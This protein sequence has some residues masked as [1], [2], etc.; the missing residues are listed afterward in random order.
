MDASA[1]SRKY[2]LLRSFHLLLQS[3][4][5][6]YLPPVKRA[7]DPSAWNTRLSSHSRSPC[8]RITGQKHPRLKPTNQ[9]LLELL[10]LWAT[11]RKAANICRPPWNSGNS[12]I[13]SSAYLTTECRP[14]AV[15][16]AR[17]Y[18]S[19]IALG[20]SPCTA[21]KIDNIFLR[22]APLGHHRKYERNIVGRHFQSDYLVQDSSD[23]C[24]SRSQDIQALPHPTRI[25]G[26]PYHNSFDGHLSHT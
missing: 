23:N 9:K 24:H 5:P 6:H 22:L 21:N 26:Y 11:A 16:I 15:N 25:R 20:T 12:H 8:K 14:I 3:S 2:S 10:V 18:E 7:G 1:L 19:T 13:E 17:P 4:K